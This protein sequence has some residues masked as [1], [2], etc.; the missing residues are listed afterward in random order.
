M[1]LKLYGRPGSGSGVCEAI[2]ALTGANAEIIDLGRW[3]D[4]EPP[5]ELVA[6]NALGQIPVL[7]F[8]DGTTMTESAAISIYLADM[9]PKA[10][11]APKSDEERAAYLR[12]MIFMAANL[13]MTELRI[14]Y[15]HRY[16]ETESVVAAARERRLV[17]WK[18]LADALGERDFLVGDHMSAADLY[19]AMLMSWAEDPDD[20]V[21]R[22]PNLGRLYRRVTDVPAVNAVWARHAMPV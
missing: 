5:A 15:P 20:F 1:T 2:L 9:F 22:F 16:G 8:P 11:L 19:A 4:G 10:G 6:I 13:Y 14:F 18:V 7:V 21:H 12:W 3:P 17:E